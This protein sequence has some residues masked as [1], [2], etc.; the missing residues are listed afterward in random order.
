ML[1]ATLLPPASEKLQEAS[2]AQGFNAWATRELQGPA[3]SYDPAPARLGAELTAILGAALAGA[4]K[5]PIVSGGSSL[6]WK[7]LSEAR[8]CGHLCCPWRLQ[9]GAQDS[10]EG[11]R[12]GVLE[13]TVISFLWERGKDEDSVDGR[14]GCRSW[15][16][17]CSAHH[18]VPA[19]STWPCSIYTWQINELTKPLFLASHTLLLG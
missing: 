6:P 5:S 9:G 2:E 11:K 3:P 4:T 7:N 15:G 14:T 8:G 1:P 18:C 13:V 19:P 12:V 10:I 16:H 17:V